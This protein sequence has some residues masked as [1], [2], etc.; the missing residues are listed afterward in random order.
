M[1]KY[2]LLLVLIAILTISC[3]D[4]AQEEVALF[5]STTTAVELKPV[6]VKFSAY[7]DRNSSDQNFSEQNCDTDKYKN[8]SMK[9]TYNGTS[10]TVTNVF[11]IN[12]CLFESN[13]NS[14]T[15]KFNGIITEDEGDLIFISGYC[16][17]QM[18]SGSLKGE[19]KISSGTGK[20]SSSQ[21]TLTIE[22]SI[23]FNSGHIT[24]DG[25]GFISHK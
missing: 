4:T 20:F 9:V 13:E 8:A 19:L 23:D 5:E 6:E 10:R 14:L 17:I 7:I 2:P 21:G 15:E 22:G 11:N 25:K 18:E 3:S 12:D 24:W 16:T 1:K